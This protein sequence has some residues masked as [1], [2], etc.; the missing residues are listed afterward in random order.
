MTS[1]DWR[2]T[3]RQTV[4]GGAG[5]LV[6]AALA[7]P[8]CKDDPKKAG[9]E[10]GT[11]EPD[12][13]VALDAERVT[14]ALTAVLSDSPWADRAEDF[15]R[16]LQEILDQLRAEGMDATADTLAAGA[17]DVLAPISDIASAAIANQ[18]R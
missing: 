14:A 1:M 6:A 12:G 11:S 17:N 3:R 15:S 7:L 13:P 8:G 10:G 2:W 9:Q 18:I 4:V 5:G 16:D